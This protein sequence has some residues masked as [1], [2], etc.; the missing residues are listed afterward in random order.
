MANTV[1]HRLVLLDRDCFA[2]G[3]PAGRGQASGQYL[4]EKTSRS[5]D[6]RAQCRRSAEHTTGEGAGGREWA[7][8]KG[9]GSAFKITW[10]PAPGDNNRIGARGGG[11]QFRLSR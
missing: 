3:A 8:R 2:G 10:A 4:H 7:R 5:P 11:R 1:R 9:Q 6:L